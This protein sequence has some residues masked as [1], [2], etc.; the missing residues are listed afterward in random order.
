L[1]YKPAA[2]PVLLAPQIM[3]ESFEPVWSPTPQQVADT[4]LAGLMR[5]LRIPDYASLHQFSITRRGEFWDHV[6]RG[7]E[8]RFVQPPDRVLDE[9]CDP[10]HPRWLAGARLNIADSCFTAPARKIAIIDGDAEGRLKSTSYGELEAATNLVAH[11]LTKLGVRPGDR[12]G[13]V[14]PMTAEAVAVYLGI[15]RAGCVVVSIADSFAAGQIAARLVLAGAR[16]VF[17]QG[18]MRRGGRLLELYEKVAAAGP[19]KIVVAEGR[20]GSHVRLRSSDVFM[21][22][23]LRDASLTYSHALHDPAEPTN[24]LFSSGTTGEPKAI[25]WTH[26]TPIKCAAD[27]WLHHDVKGEDVLCWPTSLGW[28]MGPWLIYAAMIN[29]ATMAI[30]ED[31]PTTRGFA[32]F[33]SRAGVTML[34]VVPSIVS[35]WRAGGTLEGLDLEKIRRYSSTGE[36]SNPD[37]M[38]WLM[39]RTT[40]PRPVI[41]YCGGTEIGGGYITSTLV[42]PNAPSTFTTAALGLDF[43]LLDETGRETD[44]GEVF[45]VPP[46]IGLSTELLGADHD[47]VYYG[48]GFVRDGVPL[49]SHGDQIERL[50]DGGYRALGRVDDTMNL[51]GIKVSS[52]EIERVLNTVPGVRETAAIAVPPT[53][54]GPSLLVI[55]AVSAPGTGSGADLRSSM[56]QAIREKL[57]PLFQIHEVRMVDA[58]PR[59][60]SNKVMRRELRTRYQD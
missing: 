36:C 23:F 22:R 39:T 49:R 53:G 38:R 3:A 31:A 55:F 16:V 45:L 30:Y 40:T 21:D 57:N 60:A 13:V 52:A 28:M 11:G 56:Q 20:C 29:G 1:N 15:V 35:Q 8:I 4:N 10:R 34:G 12:V 58:L 41:E 37:D 26:T 24:I 54:G 25:P 27:A 51:G 44:N 50:P 14:M 48:S 9:P 6:V 17:T 59:T 19:D 18:L 43:V 7:L 33:V 42:Q 32:E 5:R 47:A 2:L 46:S